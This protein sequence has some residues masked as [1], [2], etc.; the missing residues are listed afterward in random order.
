MTSDRIT[1]LGCVTG[2]GGAPSC[3]S[4]ID[5]CD[6]C[7]DSFGACRL[8][9]HALAPPHHRARRLRHARERPCVSVE[10]DCSASA[11]SRIVRH[12]VPSWTGLV[13]L[14][15]MALSLQQ[16]HLIRVEPGQSPY[17]LL[18]TP[19]WVYEVSW[20]AAATGEVL[21]GPDLAARA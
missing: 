3:P 12:T 16:E 14:R 2:P 18:K 11:A 9:H 4:V 5:D 17:D 19:A 7:E 10:D 13:V 1:D 6:A 21:K 15:L 8:G 20:S